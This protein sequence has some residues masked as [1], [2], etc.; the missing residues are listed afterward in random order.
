LHLIGLASGCAELTELTLV[1]ATPAVSQPALHQ[2]QIA[3]TR[4]AAYRTTSSRLNAWCQFEEPAG[5]NR[6]QTNK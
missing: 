3:I 1:R 5:H 2:R 6:R 4:D